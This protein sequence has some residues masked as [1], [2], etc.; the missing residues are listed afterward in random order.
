MI[1][2]CIFVKND[3]GRSF[4]S[5]LSVSCSG[6][7]VYLPILFFFILVVLFS[8][9]SFLPTFSPRHSLCSIINIFYVILYVLFFLLFFF[10]SN[11]SLPGTLYMYLSIYFLLFL[12]SSF[13]SFF[14]F[15]PFP[16]PVRLRPSATPPPG[17]LSMKGKQQ[18]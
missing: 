12:L 14:F 10:S 11:F 9:Y 1:I 15:F 7:Y 8:S 4:F 5:S 3:T 16:L 2:F 6:I 17:H 13:S 18:Q